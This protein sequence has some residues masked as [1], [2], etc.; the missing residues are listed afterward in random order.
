MPAERDLTSA[1]LGQRSCGEIERDDHAPSG[2][3]AADAGALEAG[4]R[5]QEI[6]MAS[7]LCASVARLLC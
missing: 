5:M 4:T 7:K 1:C 6:C 3:K 2:R